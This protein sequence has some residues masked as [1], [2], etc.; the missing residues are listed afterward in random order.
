MK[1]A[2][3]SSP[4]HTIPHG[5]QKILAP[6][7]LT[8]QLV[9]VLVSHGHDVTLFAPE[10]SETS[11]R[12]ETGGV[13]P[14]GIL[15]ETFSDVDAYYA[16]LNEQSLKLFR[17]MVR[18]IS[19]LGIQV[20]HIHQGIEQLQQVLH[21]VPNT[22]QMVC[23][24]HDPVTPDRIP[25]LTDISRM[26][27]VHFIGISKAQTK[28]LPF[29]FYDVVY[30]GVDT[31]FFVPDG[32]EGERK[33]LIAGRIV[34][35]K[36]FVD[37]IRAI[38]KTNERLMMVGQNFS[39][40]P[41]TKQYFEIEIAPHIDGKQVFWE[42]VL[43]Q[44]HLLAHYQQAK[45]LLFPIHWEEAFGLVMTEAMACGTP[46]IAYDRG[47]VP[48]IV[49]D[50]I[51]GFI[52]TPADG[53]VSPVSSQRMIQHAG[54]EGIVEA[55]GR[56]QEIDREKCREHVME[57]FSVQHMVNSYEQLYE[58]ILVEYGNFIKSSA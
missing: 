50:G 47:S 37:A 12:L 39:N 5:E 30:N 25:V 23:T 46:V 2:I 40:K 33:F 35:E 16:Y 18:R 22:V 36:G 7:V 43:K 27:N 1:I 17:H 32:I 13:Q 44:E 45:A 58:K 9:T 4:A 26:P 3:Y 15:R 11:A 28:N 42:P 29:P 24:F 21:E 48:E 49:R 34:P 54:V 8:E 14:C 6:W 10:G 52:V 51:S 20:I 31:G 56:I 55:M 41:E 57:K 38:K 53:E 19:S